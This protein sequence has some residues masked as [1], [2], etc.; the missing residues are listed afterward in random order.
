MKIVHIQL[1]TAK[2]H[3]MEELDTSALSYLPLSGHYEVR[4]LLNTEMFPLRFSDSYYYDAFYGLRKLLHR[5]FYQP[6]FLA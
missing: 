1:P 6:S 4:E 3:M 5:S 2:P